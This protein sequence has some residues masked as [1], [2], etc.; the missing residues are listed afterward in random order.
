MKGKVLNAILILTSLIGYL[1]WGT[2][3]KMFLFQTELDIIL[4]LITDPASVMHP[5]IL[6]P[7]FG[8]L[9]LIITLFQ[10]Q[11]G[12]TLTFIGLGS[13]GVLL[14]FMSAIGLMGLNFKIFFSTLP[15]ILTATLTL[16]HYRKR[17]VVAG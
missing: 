14:V 12:K 8:Q 5:F 3:N 15:F 2:D 10:K 4:K 11:P 7:L 9:V 6:L 1:E 13:I 16:L 17:K